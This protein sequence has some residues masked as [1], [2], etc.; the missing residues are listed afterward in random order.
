MKFDE[1]KKVIEKI[2]PLEYGED[3]DNTGIQ[4]KAKEDEINKILVVLE[5]NDEVV[6]EAIANKV[7]MIITHHPL[8]FATIKKVD[9]NTVQGR[10][11]IEL[12]NNN[13]SVYSA[14]I[15]FDN[16]PGGNNYY[17]AEALGLENI[18]LPKYNPENHI[19]LVGEFEK[20][21]DL[22]S[23]CELIVEKWEIPKEVLKI[24]GEL[25][26]EISKVAICSGAGGDLIKLAPKEGCQLVITAD[27]KL[28]QAQKAIAEGVAF[29]DAGHYD[30]EKQ[31]V[32]NIAGKLRKKID[33]EIMESESNVNPFKYMNW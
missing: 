18:G 8:V 16:A 30:T 29:I 22:K 6:K 33:I 20:P 17:L 25:D 32:K 4:I 12:I 10:Y 26:K 14:H 13:I 19:G 2:A 28:H 7:D 3:W 15:T 5:I 1:V 9:Y 21:I 23:V 31:F 24:A 11:L 27:T